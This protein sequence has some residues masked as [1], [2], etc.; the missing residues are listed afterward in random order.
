VLPRLVVE[1]KRYQIVYV[2]G[3]HRASSCL[4]DCVL[5]W[6][7]L[8]RGGVLLVDDYLWTHPSVR[9]PPRFAVDGFVR[10]YRDQIRHL[11]R[12][13]LGQVLAWK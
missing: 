4:F 6:Q 9:I 1:G 2:D 5:G 12:T 7:L 10:S 11:A 3:D 13:H 8:E